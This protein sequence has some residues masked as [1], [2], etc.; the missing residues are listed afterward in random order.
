MLLRL[1][2]AV[3]GVAHGGLRGRF[4]GCAEVGQVS[5]VSDGERP[6]T[7]IMYYNSTSDVPAVACL[8]VVDVPAKL[9]PF[10]H[11]YAIRLYDEGLPVIEVGRRIGVDRGRV[12]KVLVDA[13][14]EVGCGEGMRRRMAALSA[15][16]RVALSAAAHDAVRGSKRGEDELVKRAAG[17]Q[18][19][20]AGATDQERAIASAMGIMPG[21][22]QQAVGKYN[23]DIG[24][25]PV[26]VEL[27][28]GGWHAHGRHRARMPQRVKDLADAGWNLLIIWTHRHHP[29]DVAVVADDAAAYVERSRSDPSF[30]RQ[31]RVIWGSGKLI[32]AGCVDDNEVTLI[33]VG[34]RGVYARR[35]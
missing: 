14:R 29:L 31:Y 1:L 23:L 4:H 6:A 5:A 18:R 30:R 33:P 28:G 16:E 27:F 24:A 32:S 19:S 34:I 11:D 13:G 26:A 12:R 35:S 21:V 9:P 2:P 25:A 15:E 3:L 7:A 8:E 10:D 22:L 17:K 20:L